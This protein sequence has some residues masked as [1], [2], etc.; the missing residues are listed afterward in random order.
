MVGDLGAPLSS[1]RVASP[2][3]L[4]T[5]SYPKGNFRR[6]GDRSGVVGVCTPYAINLPTPTTITRAN[7]PRGGSA[8]PDRIFFGD[9]DRADRVRQPSP[10]EKGPAVGVAKKMRPG[11]RT[12]TTPDDRDASHEGSKACLKPPGSRL[13]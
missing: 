2:K 4:A 13:R 6:V 5:E 7:L 12:P 10:E 1:C 8:H 9:T 3:F 11:V